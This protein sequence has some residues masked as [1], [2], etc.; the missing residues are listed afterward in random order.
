MIAR[1]G[2]GGDRFFAVSEG[3]FDVTIGGELVRTLRRGDGRGEIALLQDVP[4]TATV[5]ARGAGGLLVVDRAPF[6]VAVTGH[7]VGGPAGLPA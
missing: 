3:T 4:R 5:T 2:A 1:D 7:D 6:I